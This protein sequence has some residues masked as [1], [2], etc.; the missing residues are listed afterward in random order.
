MMVGLSVSLIATRLGRSEKAMDLRW[1][2]MS[3]RKQFD[4]LIGPKSRPGAASRP[5]AWSKFSA[6]APREAVKI[7]KIIQLN[8][9]GSGELVMDWNEL[10]VVSGI[11]IHWGLS[12]MTSI[13][14]T[15]CWTVRYQS[16]TLGLVNGKEKV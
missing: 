5:A 3:K 6:V 13:P 14:A 8:R 9:T 12:T 4:L 10:K 7:Y 16:L 1:N 2:A 15:L 11:F